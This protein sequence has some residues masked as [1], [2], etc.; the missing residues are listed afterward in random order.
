MLNDHVE[1]PRRDD[2][3]TLDLGQSVWAILR[4]VVLVVGCGLLLFGLWCGWDVFVHLRSVVQGGQN[5]EDAARPIGAAIQSDRMEVTIPGQA[6][7]VPLGAT[8][9]VLLL[10]LWNLLWIYFPVLLIK[11]GAWLM[12]L[13]I[14]EKSA[15]RKRG[16]RPT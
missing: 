16:E 13:A 2:Q 5:L 15:V 14:P 7:P 3:P 9:S 12:M 1:P 8:L 11:T 6:N 4:I 10:F